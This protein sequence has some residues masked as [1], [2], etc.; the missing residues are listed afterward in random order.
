MKTLFER[1]MYWREHQQHKHGL[2]STYAEDD[3]NKLSNVD[4]LREISETLEEM[5]KEIG[6]HNE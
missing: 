1:M 4:F 3:L 6:K 5:F 2:G